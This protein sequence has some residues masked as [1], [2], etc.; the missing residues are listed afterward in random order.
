MRIQSRLLLY[1]VVVPWLFLLA[2]LGAGRVLFRYLLL[3]SVDRALEAQAAVESVS[4]FD[5]GKGP[6]LHVSGA[7][8]LE[9]LTSFAASRA[10][11]AEGGQPVVRYSAELQPPG[12]F[13][14]AAATER[15]RLESVTM[16]GKH[17]ARVLTLAVVG[18][19][20][21]GGRYALWIGAPLEES[22]RAA[23]LYDRTALLLV[24]AFLAVLVAVN[25]RHAKGLALRLARLVEH[26]GLVRAGRLG[27]APAP[28]DAGDELTTL[29][30]AI[31]DA[32]DR[33]RMAREVQDRMI[34]D[35]AHELRTPL[36]AMRVSIDVALRR[37]RSSDELR[38]TLAETRNEV[39]RLAS[40]ATQLLELAA[41]RQARWQMEPTDLILVAREAVAAFEPLAANRQVQLAVTVGSGHPV[42][43]AH[44]PSVRRALDNLLS[45]ALAFVPHGG[46]VVVNVTG[47]ATGA[48]V[49]VS[50]NG[51]GIPEVERE[52]VFVPFHRA[53]GAPMGGTGLGLA[54]VRDIA[55]RHGGVAYASS[56]SE[57]PGVVV[58]FTLAADPR[59]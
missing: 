45:N 26:M 49:S 1:S 15:P 32:T 43:R 29:R 27:E 59:A 23:A 57:G 24:A 28:D 39:D 42:V 19:A 48:A 5:A 10:L 18:P 14:P 13:D 31:A 2:T 34:A 52:A 6:H 37:E 3:A 40:M 58:T 50:D 4:L 7:P 25:R 47:A 36:A 17:P 46:R 11:Y 12:R 22:E 44:G 33:L 55:L 53:P 8:A 35:A 9:T 54:I 20:P 16:A 38:E 56:P 51:P 21:E 41:L 30:D